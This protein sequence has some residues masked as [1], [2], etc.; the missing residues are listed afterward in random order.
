MSGQTDWLAVWP[1]AA[2][3]SAF[4]IVYGLTL[5]MGESVET[6]LFRAVAALVVVGGASLGLQVVLASIREEAPPPT[7]ASIDITLPEE[8]GDLIDAPGVALL[9]SETTEERAG[10]PRP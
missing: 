5:V 6:I 8:D 3:A 10:R 4:G 7:S 1:M 9:P 2:A